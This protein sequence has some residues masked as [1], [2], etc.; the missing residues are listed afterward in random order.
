M[1]FLN[2]FSYPSTHHTSFIYLLIVSVFFSGIAG[3]AYAQDALR[4]AD[5]LTAHLRITSLQKRIKNQRER[6]DKGLKDKRITADEAEDCRDLLNSIEKRTNAVVFADSSKIMCLEE[7]DAYN[8]YLDANSGLIGEQKKSE[9]EY[10]YEPR[11][12]QMTSS[13]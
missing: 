4:G 1:K 6:I 11:F 5:N 13:K 2:A 8:T 3:L 9:Y 7:F 10:V 12:R